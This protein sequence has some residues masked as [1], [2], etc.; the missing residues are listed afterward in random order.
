MEKI[1]DKYIVLESKESNGATVPADSEAQKLHTGAVGFDSQLLQY[2]MES[3]IIRS[4]MEKLTSKSRGIIGITRVLITKPKPSF[5]AGLLKASDRPLYDAF[6]TNEVF[7]SSFRIL[8]KLT[9]SAFPELRER[10]KEAKEAVP[11]LEAME[12]DD[13]KLDINKQIIAFIIYFILWFG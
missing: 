2:K 8:K 1:V 11:K 4:R 6:C 13:S 7:K 3:N 9:R 5:K 10:E 12:V